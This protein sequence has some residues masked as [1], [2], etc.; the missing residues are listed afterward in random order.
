M[1]IFRYARFKEVAHFITK[2]TE[3]DPISRSRLLNMEKMIDDILMF[4]F[5]PLDDQGLSKAEQH[6]L[7]FKSSASTDQKISE[8]FGATVDQA[9]RGELNSWAD[10]ERGLMALIL[11]LDQFTRNIYRGTPAA[12]SGDSSAL[13]LARAAIA[14][15]RHLKIPLIHRVF[16]YLPLEHSESMQDQDRCVA[17]FEEMTTATGLEQMTGFT[18]YAVAHRDVIAQF[19]RFPHRNPILGRASSPAEEAYIAT[20]GGF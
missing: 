1:M 15:N 17:L 8:L 6:G 9:L 10:S 18:R 4:W 13:A 14:E 12:F 2:I 11:L 7:W 16:L 5:G 3:R 20:H 19:E